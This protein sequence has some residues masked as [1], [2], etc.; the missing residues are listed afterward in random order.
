VLVDKAV[1]EAGRLGVD[2]LELRARQQLPGDLATSTR[3]LTVLKALPDSAEELWEHGIRAKLRSQIR[4][5]MKEGMEARFGN[6]LVDPFYEVFSRTMRD[7]GTPV[8]PKQFFAAIGERLPDQ[9]VYAAVQL[10]GRPLAAGCGF[11]WNDEF[12]LTWAGALREFSKMA[13]NM[14]LYWSL[15]E[16]SVRRG[17]RTFNFGRCSP[18]SST[19]RFKR[20]WGTEDQE[21][22]WAQWSSRGVGKTPGPSDARFRFGPAVWRRLPVGVTRAIGP[23]V[24]RSLP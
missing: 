22:P 10:G 9:V 3:K 2:L 1:A 13:P 20:Q 4:R 23:L 18:G 7:L 16:E 5:P 24:A 19:H 14:L 21:L 17:V 11:V 15:M 8:L 12:E 6:D